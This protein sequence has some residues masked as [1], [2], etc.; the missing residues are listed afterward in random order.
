M[1]ARRKINVMTN[2]GCRAGSRGG[3]GPLGLG[4]SA[5]RVVGAV[6]GLAIKTCAISSIADA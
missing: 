5:G 6:V 3:T 4:V 2:Y 1:Q